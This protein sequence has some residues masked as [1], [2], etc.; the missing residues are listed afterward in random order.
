MK[1]WTARF[2]LVAV[3]ITTAWSTWATL[4]GW[5]AEDLEHPEGISLRDE[6]VAD[7][8]LFFLSYGRRTHIGG[9]PHSGK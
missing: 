1:H 3:G 4:T 8:H 5:G 2:A 9:G 7:S 6:S